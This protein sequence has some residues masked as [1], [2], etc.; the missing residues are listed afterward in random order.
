MITKYRVL[1]AGLLSPIAA[2]ILY[3]LVYNTL[4]AL[5]RD[6][7]K[8]WLFRLS[9]SALAL[10]VPFVFTL[11]LAIKEKRR[12]A[13]SFSGKFGVVVATLSLGLVWQPVSDAIVRTR[14][15]HNQA[16]RGVDAPAFSTLDLS[17]NIQRLTDAK[18]KVVL[19]NLWATWC[20]PC[21][22]EMPELDRLYQERKDRGLIVYGLSAEPPEVQRKF[23][24][25]VHVSYPLLTFHG[26]VPA[27]YRDI[28]RYPAM[29]L[30][31][32]NGQLQPTPTPDQP[33]EKVRDTVDTFLNMAAK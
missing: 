11:F 8:D 12:G 33:F 4:R 10:A 15:S 6:L 2:I 32:R 1:L 21:R 23:L 19:I 3:L 28:V 29:F 5:S 25:Q 14:Q 7:E 16:L 27:L 18:G 22:A 17:G 24:D 30:I 9:M 26:D 20:A 13:L 31:D